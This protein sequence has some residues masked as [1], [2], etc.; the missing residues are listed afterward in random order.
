MLLQPQNIGEVIVPRSAVGMIIG[1]GGE[2]IKRMS[3]ES[4]AKIQFKQDGTLVLLAYLIS[5]HFNLTHRSE[6][7]R[8]C[9]HRLWNAR[10]DPAR[11]THDYAMC[12]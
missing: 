5:A 10:G 8:A 9:M 4:G 6:R 2:N 11:N 1:K 7:N 3:A 12:D